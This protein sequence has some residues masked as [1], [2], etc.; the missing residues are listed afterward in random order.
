MVND[1]RPGCGDLV[2]DLVDQLRA[3]HQRD[4]AALPRQAHATVRPMPWAAPVTTTTLPA[5]RPGCRS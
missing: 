4:P 3:V 5:K 2:P 1:S